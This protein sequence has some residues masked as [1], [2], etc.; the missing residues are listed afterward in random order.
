MAFRHFV[1]VDR[2][3]T[4]CFYTAARVARR[5]L[6]PPF[7]LTVW[8][9]AT[10]QLNYNTLSQVNNLVSKVQIGQP[11]LLQYNGMQLFTVVL[12]CFTVM[13]RSYDTWC[14]TVLV[15]NRPSMESRYCSIEDLSQGH[16]KTRL[17]LW[18]SHFLESYTKNGFAVKHLSP[19][20]LPLIGSM[21]HPS[22]ICV[23]GIV[24]S[25]FNSC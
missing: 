23:F 6:L 10:I 20:W 7:T 25:W 22:G 5:L 21:Q 17:F 11:P 1:V 8:P 13:L 18:L 12:V 15:L 9:A 24:S 4:S 2:K 14:H 19:D 16:R 3:V